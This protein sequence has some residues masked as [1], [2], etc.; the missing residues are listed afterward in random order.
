MPRETGSAC[1]QPTNRV[2]GHRRSTAEARP[3]LEITR[4]EKQLHARNEQQRCRDC[5]ET[6]GRR[7]EPRALARHSRRSETGSNEVE[8]SAARVAR[9]DVV[10]H[11]EATGFAARSF[12]NGDQGFRLRM[13]AR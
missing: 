1:R 9:H 5:H 7:P 10:E 3:G 13:R 2:G 4:R 6:D 12:R 8:L 11:F